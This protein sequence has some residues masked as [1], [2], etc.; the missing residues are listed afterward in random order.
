MKNSIMK[1]ALMGERFDDLHI[2]DAHC[3]MGNF[4]NY[5]FPKANIDEIIQDAAIFGV[6]KLCIAPH[7][8]ITCD[9]K[10]GNRQLMD[11]I[12]RYPEKV[13]GLLTL[14]PNFPEEIEEQFRIYYPARQFKGV[15]L[16]NDMHKYPITGENCLRVFEK[17]VSYGGY[18]LAHTWEGSEKNSIEMCI[19]VIRNYPE[20][21]FIMGHAGGL[22]DGIPKAI[23]AVN[24]YENAYLDT[25]GFEYSNTWIEEITSKADATKILFGS[26]CPFH[27][28][29]GGIS[30]I[31]FADMD[32][33]IKIKILSGNYRNLLLKYP[34]KEI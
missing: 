3:H 13:Y 16:H 21:A 26:D 31:L 27:D 32:D 14:N 5:Y 9:Y 12:D 19:D 18:V 24:T 33:E 29:R 6:E 11:A 10:A 17:L 28:L 30:R 34:K 22:P 7:S 25:S 23:K 1:R 20:I 8:A 4:Y 15:K 2:I